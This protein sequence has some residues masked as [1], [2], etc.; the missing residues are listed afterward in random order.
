MKWNNKVFAIVNAHAGR[1]RRWQ[2]MATRTVLSCSCSN[3][4]S[5]VV[6]DSFITVRGQHWRRMSPSPTKATQVATLYLEYSVS[7]R[8]ARGERYTKKL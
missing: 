3:L 6:S 1:R 4:L 8:G 5:N 7:L 2:M